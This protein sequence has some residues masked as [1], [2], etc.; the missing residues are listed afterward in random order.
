MA[1]EWENDCVGCPQGCIGCGRQE[2]YLVIYC[3][4][5][6]ESLETMYEFK[7]EDLCEACLFEAWEN[8][9]GPEF[10]IN[11]IDDTDYTDEE[12]REYLN[13]LLT[14]PAKNY[15][16]LIDLLTDNSY[17][18]WEYLKDESVINMEEEDY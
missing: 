16:E 1:R 6:G 13:D 10:D 14:H 2:D 9:G 8:W 11:L 4:N 5:C 15:L 17:S 3:D 7:G 12:K 18:E